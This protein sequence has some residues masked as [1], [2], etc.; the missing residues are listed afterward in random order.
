MGGEYSSQKRCFVR[1]IWPLFKSGSK[2]RSRQK[3][4]VPLIFDVSD[5]H[6]AQSYKYTFKKTPRRP[7]YASHVCIRISLALA[8][9][10]HERY[11]DRDMRALGPKSN[12]PAHGAAPAVQKRVPRPQ[13]ER[14]RVDVERCVP[15]VAALAWTRARCHPASGKSI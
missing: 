15:P 13:L 3:G 10:I 8:L 11:R 14:K 1:Y 12:G 2:I 9:V 4:N 5:I 6:V 7:R